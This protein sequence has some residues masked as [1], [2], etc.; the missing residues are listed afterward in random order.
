MLKGNPQTDAGV[1]AVD[2]EGVGEPAKPEVFFNKRCSFDR[3]F[4]IMVPPTGNSRV[5]KL[6]KSVNPKP[7]RCGKA[8]PS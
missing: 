2:A 3:H 5:T 1:E 6:A 7:Q 8:T 4:L